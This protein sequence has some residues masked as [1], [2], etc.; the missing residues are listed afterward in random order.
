MNPK[1]IFIYAALFGAVS[2]VLGQQS[3]FYNHR[4]Q[5]KT[6][7][8]Q[9]LYQ[10][11]VYAAAQ[12][13]FAREYYY[14][15]P[16]QSKKEAALFYTQVI[17]LILEHNYAEKGLEAFT[18]EYPKSAY[19]SLAYQPM[20]DYY[21]SKKEFDKALEN[22]NK[23]NAYTLSKEENTQ[24]I[25]KLGYAKFMLGDNQGAIQALDEAYKNA[26]GKT[27][28]DIAYMLGHLEYAQ[29]NNE[30]AFR[31]FDTIKEDADYAK[32]V[33]PYYVQLYF[34]QKNYDQ[35]IRE[36]KD[37]L[38]SE[39]SGNYN[40]EVNKIIGESYFMKKDY[41]SAFPYLKRYLDSK[42]QA[43]QTDLYEMGYVCAQLK[44]YDEA[45]G[46]YNQLVNSQS[47]LA[48]NAYY[49]LGNAYLEVGKK[50]EA[51]SAF[52][53]AAFMKYDPKIEQLAYEQ[54][55]KLGYDIGNPFETNTQV[56]QDYIAK[57]PKTSN[58]L[59]MKQL[60]V[61]AYLYSGNYKETLAALKKYDY[62]SQEANKI[63]QE[64]SFLLGTEEYNKG[65]FAA[66]EA[67]FKESLQFNLN[68]EFNA[69]AQ[70]WMGQSQY[71]LGDYA[72]STATL[73][74]LYNSSVSF[75][76][77]QQLTY[78]LAYSYFKN[79]NFAEAQK[80]FKLYL[81][82]P[83]SEFK[84]DAELRL[85]DTYYAN[86]Q[87]N[88]ALAIYDKT[89][90]ITDYTQ[91]Q[92]A[93]SLGFK[94]D[95]EAKISELKKLINQ[96]KD[97]EY[98][99]DAQYEIGIALSGD[100]KYSEANTY[101]E[102][103]AKTSN[104]PDLVAQASIYKAQNLADLGQQDKALVELKTLG[105]QYKGSSYADKVVAASKNIY[106]KKGDVSGYQYFASQLGVKIESSELD[107]INLSTAQSYFAKKDYKNAIPYYEK[108]LV[109]NPSGD[110]LFQSQ[111]EMGE[112]LYQ[113][114]N[115]AKALLVLQEV[116]DKHNDYQEDA[117]V[118]IS[119][120]QLAQ[121]N[122][123]AAKKYLTSL[124]NSTNPNIKNYALTEMMKLSAQ[125]DDFKNAERYADLI[126]QNSKNPAALKEQAQVIKARSLMKQSKDSEA[127]TAFSHLEKSANPEVAAEAL[128]AKAYYQNKAKAYKSSNETIF[129]LSNNYSSEEYWGA[130]ALVVMAKNYLALG[131]KYQAS[132]TA[133]QLIENYQDF[134][135]VVAEAKQV[136]N[137]IKK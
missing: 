52:R 18:R 12:Y 88:D 118:R 3:A 116:A 124:V 30:Q 17:G 25:L 23:V 129:K 112:S 65:N 27:R 7:L 45:V 61:K 96:Y 78:D 49:Q 120:I 1:N 81:Q 111:Y 6:D 76:E 35:A 42:E 57:Y 64:A 33:R 100:G 59:E 40:L 136:K 110:K 13:E 113:T 97:S 98:L 50:K 82:N 102:K 22:L 16:E 10:D 39:L 77:K 83:K 70:Y 41:S 132:Y 67:L 15:N 123:N 56:L 109:K 74:K 105:N 117:Q 14:Q 47:P 101:F 38:N 34:N 125:A 29:G 8:A 43:S 107:E 60:L 75:D 92:K 63:Q 122:P 32:T 94:G 137:Q 87:L 36:G 133:D 66:A 4:E 90:E 89:S 51:L 37:L 85:A 73:Q 91:Y 21:L 20:A 24:H 58:T 106:L 130:K 121:N 80:Y 28:N 54:Y 31:Y 72:A 5:Y 95:S 44:R 69:R 11:K 119:Q 127:K 115:T 55:A 53:S 86:N 9:K 99:D 131:D 135:D 128:Y 126:L 62:S 2:P 79:K 103:V 19:F 108:F 114:K 71:Q 68:K 134:A 93:L 26:Q 104:D 46:Y 84:N 48:Q